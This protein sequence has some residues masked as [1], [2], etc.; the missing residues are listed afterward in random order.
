LQRPREAELAD[1]SAYAEAI[2]SL[3]V[4]L[5]LSGRSAPPQAILVTSALPGEGKSTLVC[6]MAKHLSGYGKKV[7]VIDGDLRRPVLHR[8]LGTPIAPGLQQWLVD[9]GIV[10]VHN[11]ASAGVSLVP[12]GS[13]GNLEDARGIF[14]SE[15]LGHLVYDLKREFDVVFIDSPPLLAVADALTLSDVADQIV[16]AVR[17]A[18][19]PLAVAI[20]GLHQ[21]NEA[22]SK[23]AGVVLTFVNQ[24]Q[25]ARY[26]FG[27]AGVFHREVRRYY[28]S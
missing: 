19:T 5:R 23:I 15:A 11:G 3:C 21:I 16:I 26:G 27:D 12:A 9:G 1:R 6:S 7:A 8:L 10:A 14:D 17:W 18:K 25:Q 13:G 4:K 28:S 20:R 22:S 2:K 24:K